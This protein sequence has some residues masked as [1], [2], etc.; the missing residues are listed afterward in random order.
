MK[1][2]LDDLI[3]LHDLLEASPAEEHDKKNIPEL[4]TIVSEVNTKSSNRHLKTLTT[5]IDNWVSGEDRTTTDCTLIFLFH[6]LNNASPY[7]TYAHYIRKLQ[8]VIAE[9]MKDDVA[10]ETI[11]RDALYEEAVKD[12]PN[13]VRMDNVYKKLVLNS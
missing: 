1:I 2:A 10:L 6:P 5:L 12:I 4:L 8:Y 3:E 13:W 9:L 11:V 7:K